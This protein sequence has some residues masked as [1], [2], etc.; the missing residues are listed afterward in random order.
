MS[1]LNSSFTTS[2]ECSDMM[3]FH[4]FSKEEHSQIESNC[5]LN[6]NLVQNY[7]PIFTL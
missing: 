2:E 3:S 7:V 6:K 5:A 4:Q 1:P